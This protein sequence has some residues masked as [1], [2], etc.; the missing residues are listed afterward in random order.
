M[1]LEEPTGGRGTQSKTLKLS[2]YLIN[3]ALCH[4]D[5][6]GSGGIAPSFLTSSLDGGEWSDSRPMSLYPGRKRGRY[7]WDRSQGGPQSRSGRHGK[8]KIN[9]APDGSRTLSVERVGRRYTDSAIPTTIG[10]RRISAEIQ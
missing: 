4:E 7:P 1:V 9:L 5:I 2:L 8:E 3:Y 10:H 6:L